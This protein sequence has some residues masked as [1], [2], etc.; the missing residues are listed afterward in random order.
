MADVTIKIRENGPLLVR[1]PVT[2]ED[3]DGRAVACDGEMVA[4]CRCGESGRKPLCDGTHRGR[5][6]G[7]LAADTYA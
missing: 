1:G 6:D 2:I 5:F 7:T 3:H 4:L